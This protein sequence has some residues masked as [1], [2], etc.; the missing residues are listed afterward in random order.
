[1]KKKASE[2]FIVIDLN[3]DEM[4][5]LQQSKNDFIIFTTFVKGYTSEKE[6]QKEFKK[7]G[8]NAYI[9]EVLPTKKK[10]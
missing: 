7:R 6:A 9:F 1:M 10:V 2:L 4:E 8:Q 5:N 3:E